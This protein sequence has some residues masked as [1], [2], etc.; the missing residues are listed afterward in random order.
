MLLTC[1]G[2]SGGFD[3]NNAFNE[4]VITH[5]YAR[6][7]ERAV[8]ASQLHSAIRFGTLMTAAGAG[9]IAAGIVGLLV[10]G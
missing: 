1:V 10:V 2:L 5:G 8:Q 3:A 4:E 6:R 9:T 7:S